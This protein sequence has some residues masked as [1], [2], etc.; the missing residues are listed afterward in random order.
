MAMFD[1]LAVKK[2]VQDL[3]GKARSLKEKIEQ[4]KKQREDI[5]TAPAAKSD[6]K[7]QITQAVEERAKQYEKHF[8][9]QMDR[10]VRAPARVTDPAQLRQDLLLAITPDNGQMASFYTAETG[11]SAIFK[12]LMLE[13]LHAQVDAMDWPEQGLPAAERANAIHELDESIAK[14]ETELRELLG[15]ARSAGISIDV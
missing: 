15:S 5:A 4:L 11:M 1:F 6:I 2:T 8:R 3:A 13:G 12:R 7:A 10:F 14:L 9:R